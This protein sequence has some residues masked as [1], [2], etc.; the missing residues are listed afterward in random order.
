MKITTNRTMRRKMRVSSRIFGTP[1][2]PR[3]VVYRSN[4]YIYAQA[5]DDVSKKTMATYSSLQ[6]KKANKTDAKVTKSDQ[7]KQVG[8]KLAQLLTE[9]KIKEAVFDR[10][11]YAY[12]G[13]V[14]VLAEG[15]R[16]GK[17]K[18]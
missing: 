18:V 9:K 2:R 12:N 8:V 13:R 6:L 10:S 11:R 1:K 5:I 16:E 4:H 17:L 15:L 14:K 7:A 3:I